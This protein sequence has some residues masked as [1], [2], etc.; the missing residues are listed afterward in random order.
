[1]KVAYTG[2]V[3]ILIPAYWWQ[4]G[5]AN[6]LWFSDIALFAVGVALWLE[7][8]LLV[9]TQAVSVLLLEAAWTIDVS[10]RLLTGRHPFGLTQYMFRPGIPLW[11][12]GLSLFH[13]WLPALMLWLLSKWGYDARAW[14][15]Q[16]IAGCV[17]AV[18]C[19]FITPEKENI[20]MVF[21][22]GESPQKRMAP[23]RYLLLWMILVPSAV[24]APT[25]FLLDGLF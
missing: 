1:M 24:Y 20:N 14:W 3:A 23:A 19:Y 15:V 21:G 10:A 4:Y 6:F 2:Y 8:S 16:S 9:S 25:H 17:V 22:P 11:I 5:W 13:L 12:R 18:A 7:D